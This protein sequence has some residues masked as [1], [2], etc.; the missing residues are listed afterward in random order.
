MRGA[1]VVQSDNATEPQVAAAVAGVVCVRRFGGAA[2]RP[3]EGRAAIPRAIR[4]RPLGFPTYTQNEAQC[5]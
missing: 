3:D 5:E 1:I 2:A 4:C